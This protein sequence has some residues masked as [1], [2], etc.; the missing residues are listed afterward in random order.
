MEMIM[1]NVSVELLCEIIHFEKSLKK[2]FNQ[3]TVILAEKQ[4]KKI[5]LAYNRMD[6]V[7]QKCCDELQIEIQNLEG[8]EYEIGLPVDPLN[9][10]DFKEEAKNLYIDTM[11]EPVIKQKGSSTI[12]RNGKA[13]LA[14]KK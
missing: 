6:R 13:I 3:P 10:E 7:I 8:M 12:I 9:L 11:I 2:Q 5:E 14:E 1:E 4:K